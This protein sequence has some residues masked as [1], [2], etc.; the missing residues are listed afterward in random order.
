MTTVPEK[1]QKQITK[2]QHKIPCFYYRPFA[3]TQD[4]KVRAIDL[5]NQRIP[6]PR[7]PESFMWEEFYYAIETGSYDEVSQV[8]EDFLQAHETASAE[9]MEN[10]L[11]RL[12]G[13]DA[14]L[15]HD[16]LWISHLIAMLWLRSPYMRQMLQNLEFIH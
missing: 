7:K 4:E 13:N 2:N 1:N 14:V 9:R 8:V 3:S 16:I 15:T 6:K 10:V 11:D 5:R 12:M